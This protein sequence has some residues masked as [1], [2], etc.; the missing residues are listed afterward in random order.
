MLIYHKGLGSRANCRPASERL[1]MAVGLAHR[2]V[3]RYRNESV[4]NSRSACR[5]RFAPNSN[6]IMDDYLQLGNPNGG[7]LHRVDDVF[8]VAVLSSRETED[9]STR[10]ALVV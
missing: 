5:C 7:S 9:S 2:T 8:K 4:G 6:C 3:D 1:N 10:E